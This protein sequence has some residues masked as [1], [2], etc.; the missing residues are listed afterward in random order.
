MEE[1]ESHHLH[2]TTAER[3]H[4]VAGA[5][6]AVEPPRRWL[7]MIALALLGFILIIVGAGIAIG[8]GGKKIIEQHKE[9]IEKEEGP[10]A[11]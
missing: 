2:E 6:L 11:R 7:W 9:Q 8:L 1:H 3:V 10:G 5:P 4:R